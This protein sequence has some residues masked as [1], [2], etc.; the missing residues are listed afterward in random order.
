MKKMIYKLDIKDIYGRD[1]QD[2]I[3]F[4]YVTF[5]VRAIPLFDHMFKPFKF[6]VDFYSL[7]KPFHT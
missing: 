5:T 4:T 7:V 3:E 6:S 1:L 2:I